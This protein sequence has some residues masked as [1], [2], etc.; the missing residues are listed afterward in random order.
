MVIYIVLTLVKPYFKVCFELHRA[1]KTGL[2][3]A[4]DY[5][6]NSAP[7]PVAGKFKFKAVLE[8]LIDSYSIDTHPV[9]LIDIILLDSHFYECSGR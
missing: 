8:I 1:V 7:H 6:D 3:E 2:Y 5:E 9:V 4:M